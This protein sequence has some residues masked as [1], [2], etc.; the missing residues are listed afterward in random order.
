MRTFFRAVALTASLSPALAALGPG[1]AVL[2]STYAATASTDVVKSSG[3]WRSLPNS[4][5]GTGEDLTFSI[6]WGVITGGYSTL[7]VQGIEKIGERLAYHIVEQAHSAGVVNTFY[8]VS[9]RN[10]AWIDTGSLTT[11][12]YEK[13]IREGKYRIEEKVQMDQIGHRYTLHSY[14][15]D[16]NLYEDKA[17]TLTPNILDVL[18]SLY[19]VR[20]LPLH[21]GDTYTMD[22]FSDGKIWPL[23]LKVKK[24]QRVKVPAGKFD[25]FVVEPLLREPGVFVSKGKKLEV[26]MTE[27]ERHMPVLMRSEVF[28]GHVSAHLISYHKVDSPK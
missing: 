18:G 24:R 8:R 4:A 16:K 2:P 11:V 13:R 27:D 10:D 5:F 6:S 14:R 17:G 1:P 9:D 12:A 7:S 25:C 26:W 15:I 28:I 22:V 21:V 19:F 20:T 23:V 3:A